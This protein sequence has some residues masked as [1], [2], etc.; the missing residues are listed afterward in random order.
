MR[1]IA[2]EQRARLS[3]VESVMAVAEFARDAHLALLVEDAF[4]LVAAD[5]TQRDCDALRRAAAGE[6][7]AARTKKP[8]GVVRER[9]LPR[10]SSSANMRSPH[11]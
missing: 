10:C 11:S 9:A 2:V 1:R 6:A 5:Q 7:R 4:D 8:H 3:G